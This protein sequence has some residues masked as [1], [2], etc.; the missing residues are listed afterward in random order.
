M[1]FSEIFIIIWMKGSWWVRETSVSNCILKNNNT[2]W[3]NKFFIVIFY[4]LIEEYH[5]DV[6]YHLKEF[7]QSNHLMNQTISVIYHLNNVA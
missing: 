4:Y 2:K 7:Y 6:D 5:I 1:W 3:I